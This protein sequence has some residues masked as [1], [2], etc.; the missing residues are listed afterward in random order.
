MPFS[1][2]QGGV[3]GAILDHVDSQLQSQVDRQHIAILGLYT[4]V[5]SATSSA[6]AGLQHLASMKYR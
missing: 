5:W 6:Q 2:D 4:P 1:N 3:L